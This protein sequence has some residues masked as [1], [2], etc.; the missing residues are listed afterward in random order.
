VSKAKKLFNMLCSKSFW[1]DFFRPELNWTEK[2]VYDITYNRDTYYDNKYFRL[3]PISKYFPGRYILTLFLFLFLFSCVLFFF[4]DGTKWGKHILL[5]ENA[6]GLTFMCSIIFLMLLGLLKEFGTFFWIIILIVAFSFGCLYGKDKLGYNDDASA[7]IGALFAMISVFL[8]VALLCVKRIAGFVAGLVFRPRIV[9]DTEGKDLYGM[10]EYKF[11]Y[12]GDE[13]DGFVDRVLKR[14]FNLEYYDESYRPNSYFNVNIEE[15][16][17]LSH[18][19]IGSLIRL[20]DIRKVEILLK[21][22][23]KVDER[24]CWVVRCLYSYQ[25]EMAELLVENNVKLNFEMFR[26]NEEYGWYGYSQKNKFQFRVNDGYIGHAL[27]RLEA[28]AELMHI[29]ED[30]E[31]EKIIRERCKEMGEAVAGEEAK[32]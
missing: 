20:N 9:I 5:W 26:N 25:Y 13:F 21:K 17:S 30:Y 2:F 3:T 15:Y 4:T 31:G 1:R 7:K 24:E 28:I 14:G 10:T 16:I 29:K 6:L 19:F 23:V 22:G 8:L 12:D 18:T 27:H 32:A 11:D